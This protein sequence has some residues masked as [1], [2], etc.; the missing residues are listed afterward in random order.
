MYQIKQLGR[1]R[2]HFF[3]IDMQSALEERVSLE[4][5]CAGAADAVT[6]HYQPQVD[7]NGKFSGRRRWCAGNTRSAA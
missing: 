1:G 5:G 7:D 2:V 4:T 3:D 6:A